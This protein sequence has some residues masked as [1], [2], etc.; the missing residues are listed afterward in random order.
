MSAISFR[1][2]LFTTVV[3]GSGAL[4]GSAVANGNHHSAPLGGRSA[5]MGG[6]GIALGVDGAAPFLNPATIAR[7]EEGSLAFSSRFFRFSERTIVAFHE[8][9]PVDAGRFGALELEETT[10]QDTSLDT[11][12][13]SACYFFAS[14]SSSSPEA[15]AGKQHFALCLAKTEQSELFL[16]AVP[17]RQMS[18]G[19]IVDQTQTL[20]QEWSRRSGGPSWGYYLSDRLAVGASVFVTRSK[21]RDFVNASTVVADAATGA[22]VAASYHSS[23][24]AY[25]WELAAHFGV[26]YR[27]SDPLTLGVSV[28]TPAVHLTSGADYGTFTSFDDGAGEERIAL[29]EGSYVAK[30]PPSI[31]VGV[32]AEMGRVRVEVDAFLHA[33]Q[34]D[35]AKI[36]IDRNTVGVT[37][38]VVSANAQDDLVL[39]DDVSAVVNGGAGVE[40]FVA[41]DLSL[42]AGFETDVNALSE[43]KRASIDQRVFRSRLDVFAASLGM[44]YYGRRGDV[45]LGLRGDYGSGEIAVVNPFVQ[46]TRLEIVDQHEWGVMLILAGRLSLRNLG[47][48]AD[49]VDDALT[50]AAPSP[51]PKPREPMQR[52]PED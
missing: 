48:A 43:R 45:L 52:A 11:I 15:R 5:L 35:Y 39:S 28:R 10:L 51:A 37:G 24:N 38:G 31:G 7:I 9:G 12:P 32:G 44:A 42:L 19:R 26:T 27:L 13:D 47:S 49:R 29:G 25:S 50:G 6:T 34:S 23:L 33:G 2:A 3:A 8:P 1:A 46:P 20:R 36:E 4:A 22:A 16:N 14:S 21:Y 41:R 30:P 40:W 17:F 18:A